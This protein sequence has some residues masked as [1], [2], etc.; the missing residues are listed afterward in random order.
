M[1]GGSAEHPL[2]CARCA[3]EITHPSVAIAHAGAH[4]HT[5][6]NPHGYVFR[7]RCFSRADG[8]FPVGNASR[9]HTWFP[10]LGWRLVLCRSC[11][12]HLGWSFEDDTA[13]VVVFGLIADHLA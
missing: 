4:E 9:A 10:G 5:F 12:G 7:V 8:V 1:A 11:S 6:S 13:Q 3:A 2:R